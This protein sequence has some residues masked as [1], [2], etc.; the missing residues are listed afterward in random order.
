[1]KEVALLR[2]TLHK[3]KTMQ[4]AVLDLSRNAGGTLHST[5]TPPAPDLPSQTAAVLGVT[6]QAERKHSSLPAGVDVRVGPT[7]VHVS[8]NDGAAAN[9]HVIEDRAHVMGDRA[10][11]T[12]AVLASGPSA[13]DL[14]TRARL[15]TDLADLGT[16][17]AHLAVTP[18]SLTAQGKL[19]ADMVQ[20]DPLQSDPLRARHVTHASHD[21]LR[22]QLA[23]VDRMANAWI[24]SVKSV[25][26]KWFDRP[27]TTPR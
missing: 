1:M 2:A 15:S 4:N 9:P 20:I 5:T 22:D 3:L 17:A 27:S 18:P 16:E 26:A 6:Q 14:D 13:D 8:F 23:G 10:L 24:V 25:A 11:K 12:A 7:S 21:M 19:L